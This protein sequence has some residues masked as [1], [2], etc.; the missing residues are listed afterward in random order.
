[1]EVLLVAGLLV[2][3]VPVKSTLFFLVLTRLRMRARSATFA[4]LGLSNYSEFGLIVGAIAAKNGWV[5]AEWLLVFALALSATYVVA[6][7]ATFRS[8]RIFERLAAQLHGFE[9]EQRLPE[10]EPVGVRDTEILI[11]GMG[12]MGRICYDMLAE[13]RCGRL[14]GID[15]DPEIIARNREAGR[16]VVKGDATDG[17][18]WHRLDPST[19]KAV[20]LCMPSHQALLD[21]TRRLRAT[22]HRGLIGATT[23]F[24]DEATELSE[25]GADEV[26]A[27]A[28]E[29]GAALAQRV[30]ERTS[31]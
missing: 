16:N 12:R 3:L 21:A 11:A 31:G 25:A 17:E 6:A 2:V 14:L 13:T 15:Y 18:L 27:L 28:S 20:V 5:G 24:H 26:H 10:D 9:T 19:L 29:A 1:M 4:T 8:E 30:A 7:P 23:K 22:G